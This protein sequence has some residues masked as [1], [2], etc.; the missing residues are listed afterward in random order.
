MQTR[1]VDGDPATFQAVSVG[2]DHTWSW[3]WSTKNRELDP[4]TYR[5]YAV[6]SPHDVP[7]LAN[8]TFNYVD[9]HLKRQE[10]S[11]SVQPSTATQGSTIIINGVATGHPGPGIA[12]WVIGPEYSNRFIVNPNSVGAYSLSLDRTVTNTLDPGSYHILIQH[13]GLNDRFDVYPEGNMVRWYDAYGTKTAKDMFAFSG[14]NRIKG[15][16]AYNALILSMI[17]ENTTD[18]M[19]DQNPWPTGG[20]DY[21]FVERQ[22]TVQAPAA[23]STTTTTSTTTATATA[24]SSMTQTTTTSATSIPTTRL[25]TAITPA[26]TDSPTTISPVTT[27]TKKTPTK[28]PTINLTS[29]Q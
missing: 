21:H 10:I 26:P 24:T 22:F 23:T 19:A 29:P 14:P 13:P 8:T 18:D 20:N 5:I 27:T 12:I 17:N 11:A 7:H 1:V 9:V 16:P 25:T 3:T 6:S 15:E 2:T 4:V 28:K